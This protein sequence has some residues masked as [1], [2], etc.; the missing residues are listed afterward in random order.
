[1]HYWN[2]LSPDSLKEFVEGIGWIEEE[3]KRIEG[4]ESSYEIS[5]FGRARSLNR[6]RISN[7]GRK[8]FL[9]GAFLKQSISIK[10]GYLKIILCKEGI[11]K[12]FLAH[13]LVA[14]AFLETVPSKPYINHKFG[15]KKDNR[16]HKIEWCTQSENVLH[17]F[18]VNNRIAT[19]GKKG[20]ENP[21][22]KPVLITNRFTGEQMTFESGMMA[23]K[24]L[25]LS[26]GSL[27]RTLTGKY[28]YIKS[29][30]AKFI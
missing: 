4:Y 10:T 8:A 17:G 11:T 21:K 19:K 16:S 9:K 25:G 7:N 29:Y 15:D 26:A 20:K 23:T 27:S 24:S 5:S 22:S 2:N 18:K 6:I 28:K 13:R 30:Y 14:K 12:T 1:M 3:W